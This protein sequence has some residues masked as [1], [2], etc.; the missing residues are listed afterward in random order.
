MKTDA[1]FI[2]WM[3]VSLFLVCSVIGLLLFIPG[4]NNSFTYKPVSERRSTWC[5]IGIKLL[6]NS[7][8]NA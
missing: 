1:L 8:K 4:V 2:I 3:F 7:L 5:E 6:N